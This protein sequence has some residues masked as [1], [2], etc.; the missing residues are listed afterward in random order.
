[1]EGEGLSTPPPPSDLSRVRENSLVSPTKELTSILGKV[2]GSKLGHHNTNRV[3]SCLSSHNNYSSSTV[4]VA[5]TD[6]HQS[7]SLLNLSLIG[8]QDESV[9]LETARQSL[10]EEKHEDVGDTEVPREREVPQNNFIGI[11]KTSS[12]S[13]TNQIYEPP[14]QSQPPSRPAPFMFQRPKEFHKKTGSFGSQINLSSRNG[15]SERSLRDV[16]CHEKNSEYSSQ[17]YNKSSK[18]SGLEN[19][20]ISSDGASHQHNDSYSKTET[21]TILQECSDI[22]K[23]ST[24]TRQIASEISEKTSFVCEMTQSSGNTINWSESETQDGSPAERDHYNAQC[25]YETSHTETEET[26]TLSQ[27]IKEFNIEAKIVIRPAECEIQNTASGFIDEAQTPR[28]EEFRNE[29]KSISE[30]EEME[31]EYMNESDS[32]SVI[33]ETS[34]VQQK[35]SDHNRHISF[36]EEIQQINYEYTNEMINDDDPQ[37]EDTETDYIA[38]VKLKEGVEEDVDHKSIDEIKNIKEDEEDLFINSQQKDIIKSCIEELEKLAE[39]DTEYVPRETEIDK[40]ISA[41]AQR[42]SQEVTNRESEEVEFTT[43]EIIDSEDLEHI[44][45]ASVKSEQRRLSTQINNTI[46]VEDIEVIEKE[47]TPSPTNE[48]DEVDE[49]IEGEEVDD[50]NE[51]DEVN[52]NIE[53]E[54]MEKSGFEQ[55]QTFERRESFFLTET[56]EEERV[57]SKMQ[58]KRE[59]NR[60]IDYHNLPSLYWE[61]SVQ[62][63]H[64]KQYVETEEKAEL[65]A[66][67]DKG[68]IDLAKD[69]LSLILQK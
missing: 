6:P 19:Q 46:K 18:E 4:S 31:Q 66:E 10:S 29:V 16:S 62:N 11:I 20:E 14:A 22:N 2:S 28:Q 65:Q 23:L 38:E 30:S 49:Q 54:K 39:F 59:R 50:Q 48:N 40:Y 15:S 53:V 12:S 69:G 35:Y 21:H 43:E 8:S 36:G 42:Q 41:Q 55:T 1:M 17:P 37:T 27:D 25:R 52:Q 32:I 56:C 58:S 7:S 47:E 64:E 24:E 67:E 3:S 63:Y 51:G 60:T 44:H 26:D 61:A 57:G 5:K 68:G 9:T 34:R 45:V 13:S 33:Q